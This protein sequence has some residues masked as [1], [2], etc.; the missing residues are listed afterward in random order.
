MLRVRSGEDD[1]TGARLLHLA[2][3]AFHVKLPHRL[4][5]GL[6]FAAP[7]NLKA[8]TRCRFS[9]FRNNR[10]PHCASSKRD[11]NTGV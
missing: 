7:R 11:V 6:A 3:E 5:V 2:G 1:K 8:P 9:A 4:V 10:L